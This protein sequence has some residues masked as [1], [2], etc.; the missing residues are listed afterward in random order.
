MQIVHAET[1]KPQKSMKRTMRSLLWSTCVSLVI[2]LLSAQGSITEAKS[3]LNHVALRNF[4]PIKQTSK[5]WGVTDVS[6]LLSVPPLRGGAAT[7]DIDSVEE[8]DDSDD[9]ISTEVRNRLGLVMLTN[10]LVCLTVSQ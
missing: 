7:E 9:K 10:L 8:E 1:C 4:S 2:S 3:P 5:L 6:S